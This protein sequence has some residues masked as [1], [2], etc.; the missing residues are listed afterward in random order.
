MATVTSETEAKHGPE[1]VESLENDIQILDIET[2]ENAEDDN[3][4]DDGTGKLVSRSSSDTYMDN[5]E[6]DYA[7]SEGESVQVPSTPE[8]ICTPE[9]CLSPRDMGSTP[10]VWRGVNQPEYISH[11]VQI[12]GWIPVAV[13]AH[14]APPGAF[15]G[16]WKNSCNEKIVIDRSEVIFESGEKWFIQ[17]HSLTNLS[18][19]VGDEKFEADL[20]LASH[21]LKWSDG[22]VWIFEGQTENQQHWAAAASAP[23][24][25]AVP[26]ILWEGAQLTGEQFFP[27]DIGVVDAGMLPKNMVIPEDAQKWEICWDWSKKGWCPRGCDCDWYHPAPPPNA[28]FCQPCGV[29][30]PFADM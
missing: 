15:D 23:Q 20:D 21:C 10:P 2:Q 5:T 16:L 25:P 17:Q 4:D 7:K 30:G 12:E 13:P 24:D 18:V 22:D 1:T 19:H 26:Q 14:L 9:H 3:R 8:G 27:M 11:E 6:T 28:S 29:D